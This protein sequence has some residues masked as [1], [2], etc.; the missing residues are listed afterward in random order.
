MT[1]P[2]KNNPMQPLVKDEHGIIRFKANAIIEYILEHAAEVVHQGSPN[3]M[4]RGRLDL[5][6]L[7]MLDFPQEDREQFAQLI[8]YSVAGYHELSYVSDDSALRASEDARRQ[9]GSIKLGCRNHGCAV[10]CEDA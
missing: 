10:H 7:A 1:E 2:P 6:K 5:S 4:H 9:F 3:G 8:G